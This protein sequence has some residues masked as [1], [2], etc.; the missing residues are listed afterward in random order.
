MGGGTRGGAAPLAKVLGSAEREEAHTGGRNCRQPRRR[1]PVMT[2]IH[3][4]IP[5]SISLS[6]QSDHAAEETHVH[7]ARRSGLSDFKTV[8]LFPQGSSVGSHRLTP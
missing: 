1:R 2:S 7:H 3:R 5:R 6:D 8:D 4:S